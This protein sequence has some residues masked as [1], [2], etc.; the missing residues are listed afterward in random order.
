MLEKSTKEESKYEKTNNEGITLIALI[1]TIIILLILSG[2]AISSLGE[3]GL[4]EKTKLT[5]NITENS[6]VLENQTLL[7]YENQIDE[8]NGSG[9]KLFEIDEHIQVDKKIYITVIQEMIKQEQEQKIIL[10]LH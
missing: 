3:N 7:E 6:K 5:K 10:M 8:L 9:E 1:I 2:I 4:F